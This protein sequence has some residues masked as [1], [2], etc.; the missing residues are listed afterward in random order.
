MNWKEIYKQQKLIS[1]DEAASKIK[2]H[3]RVM[4][5]PGSSAPADII[6][7]IA[8]RYRELE[9]VTMFTYL[10]LYPFE[11]LSQEYIGHIKHHTLFMGPFERKMASQHNVEA[12]SYQFSQT[13]WVVRNRVKPSVFIAEVSE[14]DEDGNMSFGPMGTTYGHISA[15]VADTIIVQVNREVPYVYGSKEAFI[16]VRDVTWICEADHKIAELAPPPISEID[17]QI[18]SHMIDYI[19]DGSTI[20]LGIGCVANAVGTFLENHKDLGVHTEMLSDS[21]VT[22]VEKGAIT[23][24]KK[25]FQP[26]EMSVSFG[27]GSE[28]MYRFMDRNPM[29]KSYPVAY[30]CDP[31]NIAANPNFV[32]INNTL[33]CDLTGQACSESLG[34]NQFSGTGGQVNFVRGAVHSEGGKSFLAFPSTATLKDGTVTSRISAVLPPGMAVTTTR[35]DAQY[36]VTEYGIADVRN[37][38]IAERVQEMVKIAHPDFREQLLRDARQH[39][40]PRTKAQV[41]VGATGFAEVRS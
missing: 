41:A 36:F 25:K 2:S 5:S 6:H 3:D 10:V 24:A 27:L 11:Y 26:G 34:F 14:P 4:Y 20:Q 29:V 8:R 21:M 7:A 37:K 22:L 38:S 23:C 17:R 31:I 33:M 13:D 30:I 18:A 19:E 1:V 12:T 35:T 28:K 39:C 40:L 15:H 32:S 16:N 9:D